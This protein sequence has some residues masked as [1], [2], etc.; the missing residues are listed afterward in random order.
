MGQHGHR[1]MYYMTGLPGWM[2]FGYSP[3]WGGMPPMANY[4][5]QTGQMPQAINWFQ[6]QMPITQQQVPMSPQMPM[7]NPMGMPMQITPEQ[8]KQMLQ[9]QVKM[10]GDQVKQMKDRLKEIEKEG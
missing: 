7:Q 8:E 2:R 3:G 1:N 6:Q 10:L 4:L 9:D 5:M